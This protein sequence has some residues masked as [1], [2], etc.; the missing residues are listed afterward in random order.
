MVRRRQSVIAM[1][2]NGSYM[3]RD[4]RLIF[5]FDKVCS[6]YLPTDLEKMSGEP[7]RP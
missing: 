6:D 3:E 5:W 2:G 4:D 7:I 1:E